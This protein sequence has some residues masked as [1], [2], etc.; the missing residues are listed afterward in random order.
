MLF[1]LPTP[2]RSALV[3]RRGAPPPSDLS[4][5]TAL[6]CLV[7]AAPLDDERRM[8][9]LVESDWSTALL[10]CR[11]LSLSSKRRHPSVGDHRI[12][13]PEFQVL[14]HHT[15]ETS[16]GNVGGIVGRGAPSRMSR[17]VTWK[18]ASANPGRIT[19]RCRSLASAARS[20]RRLCSC[21]GSVI[22]RLSHFASASPV[23]A[24]TPPDFSSGSS[25]VG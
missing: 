2:G 23:S 22:H 14:M 19:N 10:Y 8:T 3:A 7:A 4:P 21:S 24:T 13:S 17:S 1:K 11:E 20:F 25:I 15:C 16:P 6:L 12:P 5:W 9:G 18:D